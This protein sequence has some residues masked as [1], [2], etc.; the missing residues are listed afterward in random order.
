[1]LH[2]WM[3]NYIDIRKGTKLYALYFLQYTG[4]LTHE[5]SRVGQS[6]PVYSMLAGPDSDVTRAIKYT[7]VEI[8]TR[9]PTKDE[10]AGANQIIR[11]GSDTMS[12]FADFRW[13][14]L[15]CNEFRFVP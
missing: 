6:E 14:L 3:P 7:Y 13:I 5:A 11:E 4:R 15:N 2:E 8:L 12:G 9:L 10:V 1:M